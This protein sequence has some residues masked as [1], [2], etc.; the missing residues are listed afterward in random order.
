MAKRGSPAVVEVLL[1]AGAD[2]NARNESGST[3][4]H[5]AIWNNENLAV[6]EVLLAAGA[7]LMARTND[8]ATPLHRAA[9]RMP[10]KIIICGGTEDMHTGAAMLEQYLR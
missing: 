1:A 6:I 2:P 3:P 7:A 8:G 4:L 10:N 9:T 5:E